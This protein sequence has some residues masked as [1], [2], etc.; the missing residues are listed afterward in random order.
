MP[1]GGT[2]KGSFILKTM[3]IGLIGAG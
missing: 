2:G 1:A 3:Q